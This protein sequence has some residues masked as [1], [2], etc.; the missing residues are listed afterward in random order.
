MPF[1]EPEQT[2]LIDVASVAER[3]PEVSSTDTQLGSPTPAALG[4]PPEASGAAQSPAGSRPAMLAERV[5]ASLAD[6]AIFWCCYFAGVAS[7]HR[8]L[9]GAWLGPIPT[10]GWAGLVF[11]GVFAL[12][13]FCFYLLTES[14][15]FAT[16]GKWACGLRVRR[17]DGGNPSLTAILVRNLFR[18][19]D[20]APL[21]LVALICMEATI[22][23]QRLGDLVAGTVVIRRERRHIA[24]SD[25][26]Y[27][28]TL[29]RLLAGLVDLGV[30]AAFAGGWLLCLH[31]GRPVQSAWLL[32]TWPIAAVAFVS[33]PL[34]LTQSSLGKWLLGL[35]VVAEDGSRISFAQ[36]L[37]RTIFLPL[38]WPGLGALCIALS[39][40]WQRIG[41]GVAGTVVVRRARRAAGAIGLAVSLACA[42]A[43]AWVGWRNPANLMR[44]PDFEWRAI[45][46]RIDRLPSWPARKATEPLAI[47][48]FRSAAGS[49]E[50]KRTPPTFLPGE[51]A[52]FLFEVHGYTKDDRQVWIQQDLVIRYPDGSFGLRQENMIDYKQI[53][54]GTGAIE[55]INNVNLPLTAMPGTY[56][57]F[58]TLRDRLAGTQT[59]LQ[60]SF[61]VMGEAPP[62]QPE[63]ETKAIQ[64]RIEQTLPPPTVIPA[65]ALPG[66]S[67]TPSAPPPTSAPTGPTVLPAPMLPTPPAPESA[68]TPSTPTTPT[69]EAP[70]VP[71]APAPASETP[72]P[73]T[74]P[75]PTAPERSTAPATE[76]PTTLP[77]PNLPE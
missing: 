26:V 56:Q 9:H 27:G 68:P 19:L 46:P 61:D 34:A 14:V 16:P 33:A 65:P 3:L 75:V 23:R 10:I 5:A 12:L 4:L 47:R 2:E 69:P 24:Q 36:A 48:N 74:P 31:P 1:D 57:V 67:P 40:K 50:S 37:L 6:A 71:T 20:L 21:C 59:M 60:Q 70:A 55:L 8:V 41:D 7:Y 54:R 66:P 13:L 38:D 35:A 30:I 45:V 32:L 76:G 29:A 25:L 64:E 73:A 63:A 72:R 15:F 43:V 51:T 58:I 62:P 17:T 28:R 77:G 39:P 49:P 42:V 18:P 53:V 11:H 52:F 44:R 22:R